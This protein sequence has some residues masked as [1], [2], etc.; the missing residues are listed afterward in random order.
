MKNF[1]KLI[2]PSNVVKTKHIKIEIDALSVGRAPNRVIAIGEIG[3]KSR[4][5]RTRVLKKYWKK[6]TIHKQ[7]KD[8]VNTTKVFSA[9]E[10]SNI[11]SKQM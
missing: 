8:W 2:G 3:A 4:G 5:T 6:R 9:I 11:E 1:I 7:L 10:N